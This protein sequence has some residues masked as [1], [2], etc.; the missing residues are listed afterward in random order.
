M[1]LFTDFVPPLNVVGL[2]LCS[3]PLLL[4][5]Q[6]NRILP[7]W[8]S[9]KVLH[10]GTGTLFILTD[11][12]DPW[13]RLGLYAV[14]LANVAALRMR[15]TYHFSD[16]RDVGITSYLLFCALTA[17]CGLPFWTMAPLFYADPA[18]ALVGRSVDT[19]KL[20][21]SKSVGGTLAVFAV[22]TCTM[23]GSSWA[24][25]LWHGAA[26]A[27]LELCAGKWDNPAIGCWLLLRAL[28]R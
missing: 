27:A 1:A 20:V 19:P 3:L 8:Q 11:F 6:L 7:A 17:W 21:G 24:M 25:A 16:A 13:A 5:V 28:G 9:R 4:F 26:L 18:G 14:V 22:A 15:A 2:G 12:S 23:F 10:M